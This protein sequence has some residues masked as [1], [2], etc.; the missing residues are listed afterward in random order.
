MRGEFAD[1]DLADIGTVEFGDVFVDRIVQL[2]F[3]AFDRSRQQRCLE[4]FSHGSDIEQG[5]R[6]D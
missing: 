2:E 6:R 5:I 1:R 3:A 4:Y